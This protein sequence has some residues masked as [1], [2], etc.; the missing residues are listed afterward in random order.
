[1][2][3]MGNDMKLLS[4]LAIVCVGLSAPIQVM[5]DMPW[6]VIPV[7]VLKVDRTSDLGFLTLYGNEVR[8]HIAQTHAE[9][10]VAFGMNR[11]STDKMKWEALDYGFSTISISSKSVSISYGTKT[12]TVDDVDFFLSE[13]GLELSRVWTNAKGLLEKDS[14]HIPMKDILKIIR[15]GEVLSIPAYED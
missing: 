15:I 2:R 6:Y 3:T 8:G 1:M 10:I 13:K 4:A 5:A 12:H 14:R 9:H 11:P 7:R